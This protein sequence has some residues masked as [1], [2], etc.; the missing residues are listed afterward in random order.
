MATPMAP[1]RVTES[2]RAVR[3]GGAL[4][5]SRE[6]WAAE[7]TDG[8][9]EIRRLEEPGTPWL[10]LR[11]ADRARGGLARSLSRARASIAAGHAETTARVYLAGQRAQEEAK[12]F[13][14]AT[15]EQVETARYRGEA[16]EW[17]R[18]RAERAARSAA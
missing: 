13:P 4:S 12:S 3:P 1:I 14:D 10:I 16:E 9:W 15:P 8:V 11:K 17:E 6:V 5:T 18:I 7:T 2:A